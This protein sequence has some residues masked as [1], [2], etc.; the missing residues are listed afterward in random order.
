M[1]VCTCE[2]VRVRMKLHRDTPSTPTSVSKPAGI[3]ARSGSSA[4]ACTT[5]FVCT[6]TIPLSELPL[7]VLSRAWQYG[8]VS[9]DS[10]AVHSARETLRGLHTSASRSSVTSRPNAIFS[11]MVVPV[12]S[13]K[14]TGFQ[15]AVLV[16]TWH[17]R[18]AT[19]KAYC[20]LH[21]N[22]PISY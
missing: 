5:W 11:R 15:T 21:N 6:N 14:P 9:V 16:L 8:A 13:T 20:E 10:M 12:H 4:H 1:A 17:V 19:S 18:H 3:V 7:P 2:Q 22:R